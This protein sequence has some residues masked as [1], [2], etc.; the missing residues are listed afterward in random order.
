MKI[1]TRLANFA[2]TV[3]ARIIVACAIAAI[4]VVI[5]VAAVIGGAYRAVTWAVGRRGKPVTP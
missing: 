1:G 5:A 2:L 3:V 4:T